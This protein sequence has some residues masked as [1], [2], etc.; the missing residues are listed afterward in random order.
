MS[1]T[2]KHLSATPNELFKSWQEL[3]EN[4]GEHAGKHVYFNDRVRRLRLKKENKRYGKF[5]S[6]AW[7]CIHLKRREDQTGF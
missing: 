7:L 5:V 1:Q 4:A 6:K 2:E 3:A